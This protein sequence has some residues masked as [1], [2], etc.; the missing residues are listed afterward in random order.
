LAVAGEKDAHEEDREE[1]QKTNGQW[2]REVHETIC[3]RDGALQ[4]YCRSFDAAG[5]V[6]G[7]GA[8]DVRG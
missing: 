7:M 8:G 4:I 1:K 5:R 2:R 6:G 3:L